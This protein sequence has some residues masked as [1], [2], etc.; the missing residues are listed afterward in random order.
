MTD[1]NPRPTLANAREAADGYLMRQVMDGSMTPDV[2]KGL[3]TDGFRVATRILSG[4][5]REGV[6]EQCIT[7]SFQAKLDEARAAGDV[8]RVISAEYTLAIWDGMLADLAA[9]LRTTG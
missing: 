4:L 9:Y 3:A 7:D 5:R 6:S 8:Q 2:A 1:T